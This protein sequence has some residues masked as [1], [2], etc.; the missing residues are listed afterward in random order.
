MQVCDEIMRLFDVL[1]AKQRNEMPTTS[2]SQDD[3]K[4]VRFPRYASQVAVGE[5]PIHDSSQVPGALTPLLLNSSRCARID[6]FLFAIA[7][8][9]LHTEEAFT[10]YGTNTCRL[11]VSGGG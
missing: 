1:E 4:P 3:R 8:R 9:P 2:I 10:Y 11:G 7:Y 5:K 6:L